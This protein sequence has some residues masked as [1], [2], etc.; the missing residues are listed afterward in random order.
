MRLL[1][2]T[3]ALIWWLVGARALSK[4]ARLAIEDPENDVHVS[5]VST[6]EI[7]TKHQLGK[8]PIVA[9]IMQNLAG[10]IAEQDFLPVPITLRH[11]QTAGA[12][13]GPHRDPFD[14]MLMAQAMSENLVLVS[15]EQVFDAYGV[16]RLW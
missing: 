5:A 7:A 15:N 2:D 10:V 6:W 12:L 13:P 9:H 4:P 8:L 1:L 11:G 14:R 16:A 3:H